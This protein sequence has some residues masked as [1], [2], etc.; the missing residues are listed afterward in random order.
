M[1]DGTSIWCEAVG[2]GPP[3]VLCNG[4]VCTTQY[5]PLFADHFARD[6]TIVRWDYRSHGRSGVPEDRRT[7]TIPQY[8]RD[9]ALVMD[10]LGVEDAVLVGHS[11][12]VQVVLEFA[13]RFPQ[14]TRGLIALCGTHKSPF[15]ALSDARA[16]H[17]AIDAVAVGART[18]EPVFWPLMKRLLRTELAISVSYKM[19]ANPDLCPRHYLETLYEH[20]TSMDGEAAIEAFRGM[21]SYDATERL[22]SIRC[23]ALII[24]GGIDTAATPELSR[25]MGQRIAG[26]ELEIYPDCSHLAMIERADAVHRSVERFL[27]EHQL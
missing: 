26:A 9:L 11:M 27:A 1:P 21:T 20:V 4:Y 23:P 14:R 24:A 16:L 15:A 6:R 13:F 22:G 18:I 19:G 12:G 8:A 5:W 17:R 10:H 3:L 2:Q 25:Q 7:Q